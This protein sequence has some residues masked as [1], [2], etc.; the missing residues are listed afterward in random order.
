MGGLIVLLPFV[1]TLLLIYWFF[2]GFEKFFS[3]FLL[4][5]IDPS[6]YFIGMGWIFALAF[7]IIFG[8]IIQIPL[9]KQAVNKFK[10]QLLKLPVINTLYTTSSDLMAFITKRGMK[11][12]K[13]VMMETKLGNV[14]GIMTQT[15]FKQLPDG[16]AEKDEVAVYIPMSYQ[17]GGFTLIV[18]KSSLKPLDI[19]VQK[20]IALTMS[21]FISGKKE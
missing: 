14:V 17:I 11:E 10:D 8:L 5:F 19:S 1:V 12:G 15:D 6:K 9:V 13:I 18:P 16:L 7:T 4:I 3:W 2:I 20:G 21:A